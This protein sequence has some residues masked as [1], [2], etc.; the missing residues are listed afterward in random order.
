MSSEWK[1]FLCGLLIGAFGMVL[2]VYYS[3]PI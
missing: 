2:Y 3:I 1:A